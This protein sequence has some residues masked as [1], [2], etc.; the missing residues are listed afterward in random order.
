MAGNRKAAEKIILDGIAELLP[1]K[2]KVSPN[3]Q[4][5]ID[6]FAGMSD[7][8]FD[9][10]MVALE[11]GLSRLAIVAPNLVEPA[12]SVARNL[13][14]ADRWGHNFFERIWIDAGNELPPYL[15][16]DPYLIF[17][18]VLRRQAQLLVK[19]MS[20]PTDNKSIDDRTGQP[21]GKSKGSRI[22]YPETQVLA[23]LGLDDCA[24]ELLKYRGGDVKGGDAMDDAISKTGGVNLKSIEALGTTVESTNT[25]S[26]L[27]TGMHLSNTL[28][29]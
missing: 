24:T 11:T 19:K 9:D 14:I 4:L 23:A 29:N 22:S 3:Q 7:K 21:T 17:E 20:V 18:V 13:E 8:A 1:S 26:A 6:L 15:S 2:E 28:V 25:L 27:L 12:L 5:Y 10:F 16:N